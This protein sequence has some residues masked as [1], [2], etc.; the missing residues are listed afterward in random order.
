MPQAPKTF[1][2]KRY[3]LAFPSV[4]FMALLMIRH[5]PLFRRKARTAADLP[6]RPK[7]QRATDES[8]FDQIVAKLGIDMNMKTSPG[9]FNEILKE[10]MLLDDFPEKE[11]IFGNKLNE[12]WSAADFLGQIKEGFEKRPP[13]VEYALEA[14]DRDLIPGANATIMTRT[15][16]QSIL[17][18]DLTVAMAESPDTMTGLLE[19][20]MKTREEGLKISRKFPKNIFDLYK[21]TGSAF[22]VAKIVTMDWVFSQY[23][24]VRK[25]GIQSLTTRQVSLSVNILE[26]LLT[27]NK[28]GF[29]AN[30]LTGVGLAV[31]PFFNAWVDNKDPFNGFIMY[32]FTGGGQ[33]TSLYETWNLAFVT[34]NE[35]NLHL[36][37][38][39]LFI[40]SVINAK[41]NEY[42]FNR[43]NSLWAT[44]NFVIFAKSP[45]AAQDQND[46]DR[47]RTLP[48][49][50]GHKKLATPWGVL[51]A[52][53]A[54]AYVKEH[55]KANLRSFWSMLWLVIKKI[56]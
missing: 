28:H 50:E 29:K 54:E 52:D 39:K 15:I 48:S 37:Y 2:L 31:N 32:E 12:E 1:F 38:P 46:P 3:L 9:L 13:L 14:L 36:I 10:D 4:I 20:V 33:W 5:F 47:K 22:E 16:H 43:A 6:R 51:N 24:K 55:D 30:A 41:P 40:P 7:A 53:Y 45:L 44:A 25:E 17:L 42:L 27:E 11:Q 8:G 19:F 23:E 49:F 56:L 35:E 18:E 21:V 34:G 26:A